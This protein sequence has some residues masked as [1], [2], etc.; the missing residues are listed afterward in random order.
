MKI[1]ILGSGCEKCHKLAAN[2]QTAV[3]KLGIDC[4][5]EK[6]TD[7][8]KITEFGVMMTPAL[9]IDGKVVSS[10]KVLTPDAIATLLTGDELQTAGNK[11]Q[12]TTE[13]DEPC[14]G[15]ASTPV[16]APSCC[17]GKGKKILTV[18]L[19][20]FVLASVAL[21]I[22]RESKS[23]TISSSSE[24]QNSTIPAKEGALTV[25]Y[26]HGV[27]RCATCQKIEKLTTKAIKNKY[28]EA[29]ADGSLV[30][31]SVNIDEPANEHFIKDFQL[32]IR[33][34]VMQKDG[35]YEKFDDVWS[36]V[37]EPDKFATYI[38]NG[39]DKLRK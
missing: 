14:C 12:E 15:C 33:S 21:M 10:G 16:T 17:C 32:S 25:Y 22:Y 6:V 23:E 35:K 19:I 30:F 36:L 9:A 24:V 29:L 20:L 3:K 4:E 11:A 27:Q 7:I 1:Q 34:V 2:A 26:F 37:G 8:N 18:I 5:I 28:S 38:Q 39:V 31:K 13:S